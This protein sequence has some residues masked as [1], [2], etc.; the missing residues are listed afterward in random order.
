[1]LQLKVRNAYDLNF[2]FIA[3]WAMFLSEIVINSYGISILR[4][5]QGHRHV[6]DIYK[7]HREMVGP[8]SANVI[9]FTC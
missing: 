8:L 4:L 7:F 5:L 3:R 2:V 1:M 9:L 6:I